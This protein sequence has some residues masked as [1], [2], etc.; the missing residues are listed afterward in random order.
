MNKNSI[1]CLLAERTKSL[2]SFTVTW[3]SIR[4]SSG[5]SPVTLN[6]L[7]ELFTCPKEKAFQNGDNIMQFIGNRLSKK[8]RSKYKTAK[9]NGK[10]S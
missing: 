7:S 9:L 2:E 5:P 4:I 1:I 10:R 3:G 6:P 8:Y